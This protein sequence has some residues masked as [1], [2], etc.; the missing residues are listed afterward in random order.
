MHSICREV[1]NEAHKLA[2][3]ALSLGRNKIWRD[4]FPITVNND[5]TVV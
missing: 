4:A 1:N 3:L 2:K 5:V